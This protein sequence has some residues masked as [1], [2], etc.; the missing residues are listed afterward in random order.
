MEITNTPIEDLVPYTNNP[1][2]ND[3]AV[4]SV[5]KSIQ[6]FGFKVPIILDNDNVIITGHTRL[7]AAKQLG[8]KEVPTIKAEDLTPE[9]VKAFRIMDNK[10][11]EYSGWDWELLKTEFESMDNLNLTGFTEAEIDKIMD[12]KEEEST[13]GKKEPKY[14]IKPGDIYQLGKHRIICGDSTKEETYLN[15]I[16]KGTSIQCVF[17]DPPYGVSYSGISNQGR[18]SPKRGNN[19]TWDVIEGDDLRGDD[20]YNLIND[21]FTQVNQH[22][23]KNGS[24][25]VFH[26]SSNQIIF[27]KALNNAGF[28][29]KQQLI[30]NK[31]HVLGRSHYHWCHEPLFY[32]CRIG[33]APLFVGT[34]S[35]RTILNTLDPEKMT[36]EELKR[37]VK[38]IKEES[39]MWDIKKDN[40]Q[41]YI[42]PTQKP[43]KLAI[44]AMVNSS[45]VGD[46]ILDPFAGSGSTLM[47]CEERNRVCYTIELDPVF[48][49]HIIQRWEDS[50]GNK[51]VKLTKDDK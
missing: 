43:T 44:R 31:H 25:Y 10:S 7:K 13:Q 45:K 39:T 9:Q 20:L 16:P 18:K 47:A 12:F 3:K 40:S 29:I 46:I 24:I 51:V 35:N 2:K 36:I 26:S 22:L 50:T 4:D 32:G 30:W 23:I 38:K 5:A 34:R 17:T 15:L 14:D 49:S 41:D 48:C 8:M 19:R 11:Q 42:H 28:E 37:L 27:E 1:R 6:E 21:S 33:E